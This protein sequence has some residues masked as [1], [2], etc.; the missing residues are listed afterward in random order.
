MKRITTALAALS[1][2]AMPALAS[3][4]TQTDVKSP[5]SA[6]ESRAD[7]AAEMSADSVKVR[8]LF[9]TRDIVGKA[10]YA[11]NEH[12]FADMEEGPTAVGENWV[13][14]GK[15]N[16]IILTDDGR[17]LGIDAVVDPSI[18]GSEEHVFI[19][20]ADLRVAQTGAG[21]R[22][23]AV[24]HSSEKLGELRRLGTSFWE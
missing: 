16:D 10:I 5:G 2:F 15:V 20:V 18:L 9:G 6:F 24:T 19:P 4:E 17:L 21:E 14:I 11:S 12:D 13:N 8:E 23:Y 7:M 3:E 1:V 22:V